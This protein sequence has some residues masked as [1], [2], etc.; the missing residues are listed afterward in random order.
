[1]RRYATYHKTPAG[2]NL[3]I[4]EVI[5]VTTTRGRIYEFGIGS[6]SAPADIATEFEM[7]RGTVSGTGTALNENPLDGAD[8]VA[9]L[10]AKG[11]TF[12]TQTKT[13]NSSLWAKAINQRASY[14]WVAVPDG[15]LVIPATADAWIGLESIASGGTPSIKA[16]IYW[17]E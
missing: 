14:R 8:P 7:I 2:T 1:M 17:Q 9:L 5:G 15:E 16:M 6:D 10:S 13:T 11:G 3:T 12:A 4:L